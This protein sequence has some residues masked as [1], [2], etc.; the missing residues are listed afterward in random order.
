MSSTAAEYLASAGMSR[1]RSAAEKRSIRNPRRAIIFVAIS[2][3]LMRWFVPGR[4]EV[5]GKHTDYA[6]GRSLLCTA[7]RGFCVAA[8]AR[9]DSV[10][11]I[12]D[13]VRQQS[14]EFTISSELAIPT[15]GW[16]VFPMVVARRLARN[17]P[18]AIEAQTSHW[19]ATFRR[20]PA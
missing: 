9:K 11:R 14:L 8:V 4:I 1:S 18:G 20:P 7:E 3:E 17:F 15:S 5:L 12:N 16:K 10:V 19:P 6:G 2:T 13:V